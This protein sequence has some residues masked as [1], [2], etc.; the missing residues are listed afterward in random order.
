MKGYAEGFQSVFF[1]QTQFAEAEEVF[2]EV[3]GKVA[4]DELFAA[5][6]EGANAVCACVVA[7]CW[8]L[9]GVSKHSVRVHIAMLTNKSARCDFILS[10][11]TPSFVP[12]LSTSSLT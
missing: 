2:V 3:F 7:E 6:V 12:N 1:G 10:C 4:A 8:P 11:T 5:V 9:E